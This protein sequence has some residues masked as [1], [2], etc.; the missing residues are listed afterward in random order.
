MYSSL[1]C[2]FH[3]STIWKKKTRENQKNQKKQKNQKNQKKQK[4]QRFGN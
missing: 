3:Y 4:N 2:A 1:I